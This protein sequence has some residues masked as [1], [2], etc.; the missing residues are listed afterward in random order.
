VAWRYPIPR[1]RLGGLRRD[2]RRAA[3]RRSPFGVGK[4]LKLCG[5][6]RPRRKAHSFRLAPARRNNNATRARRGQTAC[7]SRFLAIRIRWCAR[8][9]LQTHPWTYAALVP[10]WRSFRELRLGLYPTSRTI[11][12]RS[13]LGPTPGWRS[14]RGQ[15]AL[16]GT[17]G[18]HR[19]RRGALPYIGREPPLRLTTESGLGGSV[20]GLSASGAATSLIPSR[21]GA[22]ATCVPRLRPWGSVSS[23]TWY[24]CC[25]VHGG[26]VIRRESYRRTT[27]GV[28][29]HTAAAS[30]TEVTRSASLI[31]RTLAAPACSWHDL[32]PPP[33]PPGPVPLSPPPSHASVC[34]KAM[35]RNGGPVGE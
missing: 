33:Q 22:V 6:I 16:P 18:R 9:S 20:L 32:V 10:C 31:T 27:C 3:C 11:P 19:S 29:L 24:N 30:R 2:A 34:E 35:C 7:Q 4:M 1:H 13:W 17:A 12:G 25:S 23:R 26:S 8:H 5:R 14:G 21:H 15:G 28:T